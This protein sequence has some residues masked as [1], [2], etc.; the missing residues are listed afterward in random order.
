VLAEGFVT[1]AA[2]HYGQQVAITQPE[3]MLRG[4]ERCRLHCEFSDVV[5]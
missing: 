5:A 2:A 4:D 3:C 1:G